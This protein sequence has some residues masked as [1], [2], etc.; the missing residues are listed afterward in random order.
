MFLNQV[1]PIL[2]SREWIHG[3]N[4]SDIAILTV[5][6]LRKRNMFYG[7]STHTRDT[8]N[9]TH[10]YS[11]VS[12]D[13]SINPNRQGNHIT[14]ILGIVLPFQRGAA[15]DQFISWYT[16]FSITDMESGIPPHFLRSL[17]GT[18]TRGLL[19]AIIFP[20]VPVFLF[21]IPL[22]S[23]LALVAS[24]LV[25]EYGAAAV[26]IGLGLP[27][28]YIL[29]VLICVASGVILTMFDI[30]DRVGEY[31][32]RVSRFLEKVRRTGTSFNNPDKIRDF[33]PDPLCIHPRVLCLPCSITGAGVAPGSLDPL[34]MVG[35]ISVSVLT[36]L[37]TI[38]IF[39]LVV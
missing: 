11:K 2:N 28:M 39:R 26:G 16:P 23:S 8:A 5:T 31:S 27:P 19:L 37:T 12:K 4:L 9:F 20:L 10:S 1:N 7:E 36:L 3:F 35:Y 24:T 30:F 33:W 13:C 21:G 38:G 25:I 6:A 17:F 15:K 29:Y 34:I 14:A 18:V 22:S 32:P